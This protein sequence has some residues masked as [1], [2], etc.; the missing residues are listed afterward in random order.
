MA[1]SEQ[2]GDV[3]GVSTDLWV[4]LQVK[5]CLVDE[6]TLPQP[7]MEFVLDLGDYHFGNL[8]MGINRTNENKYIEIGHPLTLCRD[9][10]SDN[11]KMSFCSCVLL[12]LQL[13][14][15]VVFVHSD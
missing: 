15:L 6:S 11:W 10:E 9:N 13:V 8:P 7:E 2:N 12:G 14:A 5:S 1:A 3:S 4:T